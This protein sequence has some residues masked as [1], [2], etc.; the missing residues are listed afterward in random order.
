MRL[1]E[2]IPADLQLVRHKSRILSM[3]IVRGDGRLDAESLQICVRTLT[4]GNILCYPTETF[5]ALGID[6]WNEKARERLYSLKGRAQEKELPLIAADSD[7]VARFCEVNDPRFVR[8]SARFWPGPLTLVV[9]SRDHR[10]NYAI[11]VTSHPV[12]SQISH[13]FR[14]PVVATSAN[15][16]GEAPV[17]NP[18]M[19]PESLRQGIETLVNSGSCTG[20]KPSTIVSLAEVP[21]RIL[22]EGV[23]PAEEILPLL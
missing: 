4:A 17:S 16:S 22:R 14:S 5:Y 18:E 12:A 6:P 3:R 2:S 19:L 21:P 1:C 15:V 9:P 8:L 13:A 10:A 23:I 20:G 11:R 7:M